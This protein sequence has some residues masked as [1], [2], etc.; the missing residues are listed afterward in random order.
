MVW[1]YIRSPVSVAPSLLPAFRTHRK[2]PSLR[3]Q[4]QK[5]LSPSQGEGLQRRV[6]GVC[7]REVDKRAP[8]L[9]GREKHWALVD[10]TFK[11]QKTLSLRPDTNRKFV[12]NLENMQAQRQE[13]D[14]TQ[15]R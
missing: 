9:P 15:K 4:V 11:T 14:T 8:P 7:K 1:H 10:D 3:E 2:Q 6:G 5:L 13:A 12:T